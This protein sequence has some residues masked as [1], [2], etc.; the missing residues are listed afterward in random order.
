M[1]SKILIADDDVQI[2]QMIRS[3]LENSGYEVITAHDGQDAV[4][5]AK[6]HKPH[7]IVLDIMMPR[8]DG[9]EAGRILRESAAT[10]DIPVIYITALKSRNDE[11]ELE[12]FEKNLVIAKPFDSNELITKVQ[13]AL[14]KPGTRA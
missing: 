2:L 1:G 12:S 9:T 13:M 11:P 8:M 6:L 10:C 3:R 4:E 5:K 7:L 14:A